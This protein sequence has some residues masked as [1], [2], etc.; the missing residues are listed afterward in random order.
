MNDRTPWTIER[1]AAGISRS[2]RVFTS[3]SYDAKDSPTAAALNCI[4]TIERL[5]SDLLP[6][7]ARHQQ[8]LPAGNSNRLHELVDLSDSVDTELVRIGNAIEA[9]ADEVEQFISSVAPSAPAKRVDALLG[10][11]AAA[12]RAAG[13]ALAVPTLPQPWAPPHWPT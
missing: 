8:L 7:L 1:Q 9:I 2:G 5:S 10:D 3:G 6:L 4:L 12:G 13:A 11:A